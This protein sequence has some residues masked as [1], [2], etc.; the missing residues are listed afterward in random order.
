[1]SEGMV[2]L[3]IRHWKLQNERFKNIEDCFP[4]KELEKVIGNAT[5]G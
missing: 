3:W 2:L 1:M 5:K 4:T